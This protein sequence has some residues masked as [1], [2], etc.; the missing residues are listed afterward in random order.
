[1]FSI[2]AS[3]HACRKQFW[4][5][6]NLQNDLFNRI[7]QFARSGSYKVTGALVKLAVES[8]GF[9]FNKLHQEVRIWRMFWVRSTIIGSSVIIFQFQCLA[10]FPSNCMKC[11][12]FHTVSIKIE[13]GLI[14]TLKIHPDW[15]IESRLDLVVL[16]ENVVYAIQV[17]VI[18]VLKINRLSLWFKVFL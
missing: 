6:L 8:D 18:F 15:Y 5:F 7:W 13:I 10:I 17:W 12:F 9:G 16:Y 3:I 14:V 11:L 4:L 1:M 2:F